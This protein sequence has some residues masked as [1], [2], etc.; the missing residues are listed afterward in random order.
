M[1][2][3]T[4]P[5]TS[6]APAE[7]GRPKWTAR[8]STWVTAAA[9]AA[10]LAIGGVAVAHSGSD[11]AAA[12]G[13]GPGQGRA[14][15]GGGPGMGQAGMAGAQHGSFITGEV[16]AVSATSI[17]VRATDGY[18]ETYPISSGTTVNGGQSQVSA[19]R[20]GHTVTVTADEDGAA[21]SILDQSLAGQGGFPGGGAPPGGTT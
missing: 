16:T 9:A 18:A 6:P 19:V 7:P 2:Q 13:T 5:A 11:T 1:D 3:Q 4:Y 21:V 10:V 17:A 12:A 20:T 8:A 14:F 15:P